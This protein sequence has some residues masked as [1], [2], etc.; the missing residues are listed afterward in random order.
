MEVGVPRRLEHGGQRKGG[1][2]RGVAWSVQPSPKWPLEGAL[3]ARRG[4]PGR[5][6]QSNPW[7]SK[8]PELVCVTTSQDGG[9]DPGHKQ[10]LKKAMAPVVAQTKGGSAPT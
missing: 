1:D 6:G 5:R 2:L 9:T 7:S 3:R 10:S 8:G 4:D